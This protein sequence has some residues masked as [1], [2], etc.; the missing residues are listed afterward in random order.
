MRCLKRNL[1]HK[2]LYNLLLLHVSD[3]RGAQNEVALTKCLTNPNEYEVDEMYILN[4]H[5]LRLN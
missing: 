4:N 3:T 5:I 2:P 1:D